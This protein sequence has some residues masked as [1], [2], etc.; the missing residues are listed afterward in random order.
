MYS[1][2]HTECQLCRQ[3]CKYSFTSILQGLQGH[4]QWFATDTVKN[5]TVC[6]YF[7]TLLMVI[8][9]LLSN[10]YD[11][12]N[13]QYYWKCCLR[14]L[15]GC[16]KGKWKNIDYNSSPQRK[17][18]I[19]AIVQKGD[20]SQWNHFIGIQAFAVLIVISDRYLYK[21]SDRPSTSQFWNYKER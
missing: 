18:G 20:M 17:T 2:N 9:S 11:T 6:F 8:S 16:K 19:C 21:C 1:C 14:G 13:I 4:R 5:T 3:L 7:V 10:T 15:K 12:K